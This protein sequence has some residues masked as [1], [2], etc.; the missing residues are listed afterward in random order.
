MC[1][2]KAFPLIFVCCF[3]LKNAYALKLKDGRE[4][5]LD[6][7]GNYKNE[8]NN[9]LKKQILP[10]L[11]K[12]RNNVNLKYRSSEVLDTKG[13]LRDDPTYLDFS[14][15]KNISNRTDFPLNHDADYNEDFVQHSNRLKSYNRGKYENVDTSQKRK[16]NESNRKFSPEKDEQKYKNI[17]LDNNS[18]TTSS[19]PEEHLFNKTPRDNKLELNNYNDKVFASDD[20]GALEDFVD[21]SDENAADTF[22]N[23]EIS[24]DDV[25]DL[26]NDGNTDEDTSDTFFNADDSDSDDDLFNGDDLDEDAADTFFNVD[27]SDND[28]D[29]LFNGEDL[30][31]RASDTFF[32]ADDSDDDTDSLFDSDDLEKGAAD[33]FFNGDT[34][35]DITDDLFS[36]DN[37]DE[38]TAD[39]YFNGDTADDDVDDLFNVDDLDEDAADTFINDDS[40]V[41]DTDDLFNGDHSDENEPGMFFN[42]NNTTDNF[43]NRDNFDDD[44]FGSSIIN[45]DS[46]LG[47]ISHALPKDDDYLMENDEDIS[48]NF[49]SLKS[50]NSSRS[51]THDYTTLNNENNLLNDNINEQLSTITHDL[52][53]T[54]KN[55]DK[56]GVRNAPYK[57]YH[58]FTNENEE[59]FID[60]PGEYFPLDQNIK[61]NNMGKSSPTDKLST[62]SE[63]AA[64]TKDALHYKREND[65]KGKFNSKNTLNT[66][67]G[68]NNAERTRATDTLSNNYKNG[69]IDK[70]NENRETDTKNQTSAKKKPTPKDKNDVADI[71]TSKEKPNSKDKLASKNIT[72]AKE[73][74]TSKD[75]TSTKEKPI[76]KDE[77]ITKEKPTSKDKTSTKEKPISKDEIITK[78]KPT[79][80]D[81]TSTKEKPISKDKLASKNINDA[82]EETTTKQKTNSK[83]KPTSKGK[84][85]AKEKHSSKDK[86]DVVDKSTSKEN[87]SNKSKLASKD[88]NFTKEK[89]TSKDKSEVADKSTSKEKSIS[90]D[91]PTSKSGASTQEKPTSEQNISTKDRENTNNKTN[92][93]EKATY[94]K[95]T[96]S[97]DTLNGNNNIKYS[98]KNNLNTE[99]KLK[100]NKKSTSDNPIGADNTSSINESTAEKKYNSNS[101]AKN[102]SAINTV[103]DLSNSNKTNVEENSNEEEAPIMIRSNISNTDSSGTLSNETK[104]QHNG[105][106]PTNG[107][108]VNINIISNPNYEISDANL[109]NKKKHKVSLK[110]K[111]RRHHML[112]KR[113]N[114]SGRDN[115]GGRVYRDY[116]K[117]ATLDE[118]LNSGETLERKKLLRNLRNEKKR[119]KNVNYDINSNSS[120]DVNS[121]T[122][123]DI[124]NNISRVLYNLLNSRNNTS[125]KHEEY[126]S[127]E[128]NEN[129]FN[130]GTPD[131]SVSIEIPKEM[132]KLENAK[133]FIPIRR[134]GNNEAD[135]SFV[136]TIVES[137]N[138]RINMKMEDDVADAEADRNGDGDDNI[139]G[140]EVHL[141]K[142]YNSESDL[143]MEKM[144]EDNNLERFDDGESVKD[145]TG[146]E[147]PMIKKKK[148]VI[149]NSRKVY[150]INLY[151]C[152]FIE[153]WDLNH[154]YIDEE[155]TLVKLSGYV[156]QNVVNSDSMPTTNITDWKLKGSCDYDKYICGGLKYMNNMYSKGERVIFEGKIYEATSEAYGTP[157]EMENVWIEKTSD[158]YNF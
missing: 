156:F 90:K 46:N 105:I 56:I 102:N 95:K 53:R 58:D 75:K 151:N 17:N 20:D 113:K 87:P 13:T 35:D 21:Y 42:D 65:I 106:N 62:N 137:D 91:T 100:T 27:D 3:L 139:G 131:V 6:E 84:K 82:K 115:M 92:N 64:N 47:N 30:D 5:F 149:K 145:I 114:G 68:T 155:G 150:N 48:N 138:S 34:S 144:K 133:S 79:S 71:P 146:T 123:S 31:E 125:G 99:N 28:N 119:Q 128:E 112:P 7:L 157:K 89:L 134:K 76:S 16:T 25:D 96:D 26:F 38:V 74:P 15:G 135:A 37:S 77:I 59:T 2:K 127:S 152:S 61:P 52:L 72:D 116:N 101:E 147:H 14:K 97:S 60:N 11:S 154:E 153:D 10:N 121:N 1:V 49:H 103:G 124:N 81:K 83:E 70:S 55:I 23:S 40:Y 50:S 120:S 148:N 117:V 39:T 66:S 36:G 54:N 12:R 32:N 18:N 41:D 24:D 158:C 86:T 141:D 94:Q 118:N 78:E 129:A 67:S 93:D 111:K 108:T 98:S 122:S 104:S 80:K 4:Y 110:N 107:E 130:I 22:F 132:N 140:D 142:S 143:I 29:G 136:Q 33:T 45:E 69:S 85:R 73:K 9:I 8:G 44:N 88:K 43:T 126:L 19:S 63:S 57:G 51:H 109:L